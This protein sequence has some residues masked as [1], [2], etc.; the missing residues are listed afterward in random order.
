MLLLSTLI[1]EAV[2][3]D[4]SL[5]NCLYRR[6]LWTCDRRGLAEL[7]GSGSRG[8]H[9]NRSHPFTDLKFHVHVRRTLCTYSKLH[10]EGQWRCFES[11]VHTW[12]FLYVFYCTHAEYCLCTYIRVRFK[13]INCRYPLSVFS[14]KVQV[15]A[16][17]L[18]TAPSQCTNRK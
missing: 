12:S 3:Q 15:S 9:K 16:S 14:F 2:P 13:H 8:W 4:W 1:H 17:C 5:V 6:C 18:I 7:I 11:A 10:C